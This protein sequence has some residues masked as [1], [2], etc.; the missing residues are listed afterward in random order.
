VKV[1]IPLIPVVHP[2]VGAG[3]GLGYVFVQGQSSPAYD[4]GFLAELPIALGG[5][6]EL[7]VITV[8]VRATYH[9]F[10]TQQFSKAPPGGAQYSGNLFDVSATVG[11]SF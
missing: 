1:A 10:L 4:N 11:V 6:I 9:Y 2:F 5:E 8:G 3:L 7:P